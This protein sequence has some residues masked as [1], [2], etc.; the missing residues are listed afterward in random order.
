MAPERLKINGERLLSRLM[1]LAAIGATEKGGVCRLAL[2][3]LDRQAREQF[4]TWASEIGCELRVDAIGNVFARRAGL[5]PDR[6]AVA[7]GSHLDTQ[8]TGGKFDGNY[9]VLAGLEVLQTLHDADIRTQAPLEVCV[10]TNEEGSRFV[11]V[12]MGSGVYCGAFT[13]EHA[14]AA[15]DTQGV[16]VAQALRAI[17]QAGPH[18]ASVD[19]GAPRF[20]AYFEAHI[21]QGPVL[22][23][24]DT[25]IG[26]VTGALGQRWYDV[27][28]TGMEAHAGPT[29]MGLR[30]DALLPATELIQRIRAIAMREQP[31]GRGTVGYLNV[32]PNSRNVIPGRVQFSVDFRHPDDAGL[33]RMD[34]ALHSAI[35]ELTTATVTISV[36]PVV[37]FP[38]QAFDPE[39]VALVRTAAAGAGFTHQE[40]VSGAGHDAVY[41]ARTAPSA[42][43]FIPCKD[44]ISHNEIEDAL[45]E[46]LI[47]GANV[48]LQAMLARAGT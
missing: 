18:P 24:A 23:D 25:T 29:P 22:E 33:L 9:G 2:T 5:D 39:L 28:V 17:D 13:L 35:A 4:S 34:A 15:T 12:M 44:G 32:F 48:L 10:W 42:M 11:P 7:T 36:N 27:T 30:R 6:S 38:P 43:I 31:N 8:P 37:Y 47:A 16:S 19:T 1:G 41:V 40:I 26:V 46:H 3:D 45:P 14:L 20:D 21:E